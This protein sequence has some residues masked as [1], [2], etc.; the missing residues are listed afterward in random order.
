MTKNIGKYEILSELGRDVMGILYRGRDSTSG[1]AVAIKAVGSILAENPD[2]LDRFYREGRAASMVQHP[3]IITV[4]EVGKDSRTPYIAYELLEGSDLAQIVAREEGGKNPLPASI[5]LKYIMQVCRALEY[6]HK[7]GIVHRDIRPGSIFV[8]AEGTV[9]LTHFSNARLP[10]DAP[11]SSG[12]F[13]LGTMGY[14]PPES[15]RGNK[16][17]GRADI[18]GVGA[19]IYEVLTY[20]KAF[21]GDN[22]GAMIFAIVSQEPEGLRDLRPDLPVELENVIRRTLKKDPSERYQ[23]MA[24]LLIDLD[25]VHRKMQEEN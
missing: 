6:A 12:T 24:D 2:F 7:R 21:Q 23:S 17:D 8:T 14:M 22:T 10:D 20:T 13:L 18:W 9:K 15:I 19:T 11:T 1:R 4:Y 16:V 3:N 5:K 25:V